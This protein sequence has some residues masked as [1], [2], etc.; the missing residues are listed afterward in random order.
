[1]S[2][3]PESFTSVVVKHLSLDAIETEQKPSPFVIENLKEDEFVAK[4][5]YTPISDYSIHEI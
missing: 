3:L 4:L 5:L 2:T 1:M